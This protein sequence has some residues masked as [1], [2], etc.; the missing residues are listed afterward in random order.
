[1]GSGERHYCWLPK[2]LCWAGAIIFVLWNS[3]P[4]Q[5]YIYSYVD[6]KGTRYIKN[7]PLETPSDQIQNNDPHLQAK[8]I[9]TVARANPASQGISHNTPDK[10]SRTKD[11]K[12]VLHITSVR[13]SRP[14][15]TQQTPPIML[16]KKQGRPNSPEITQVA[17]TGQGDLPTAEVSA[18][19]GAEEFYSLDQLNP[20]GA[21]EGVSRMALFVDQNGKM[22]IYRSK[23]ETRESSDP[24]NVT[25]ADKA[26]TDLKVSPAISD[27][28]TPP[29]VPATIQGRV[30]PQSLLPQE[31]KRP[32]VWPSGTIRVFRD[33]KGFT[34]I[35]NNN[36][37]IN[38]QLAGQKRPQPVIQAVVC[39][40]NLTASRQNLA[41]I[42]PPPEGLNNSF[43]R[44]VSFLDK[45]G[46]LTI[47]NP[48]VNA[49]NKTLQAANAPKFR[50]ENSDLEALM[51]MAA[52]QYRLPLPLVKAV[53][54]AESGFMP[55][56]VSWKG[57]MGLMQLM[58]TTAAWL[59]VKD[60]FC[61]QE[62]IMGG[63]RYLRDLLNRLNGSIPLSLAAYN[64]GLQRVINSGYQIPAIAETQ[65]FVE[66]VIGYFFNYLQQ[67]PAGRKICKSTNL[68]RTAFPLTKG[69]GRKRLAIP[70]RVEEIKG[71]SCLAA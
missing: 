43:S 2:L 42:S 49:L 17:G 18:T 69:I 13:S 15:P 10:I 4:A 22:H 37:G 20:E 28:S 29:I 70:S 5:N 24:E 12:G 55:E 53:I 39:S 68:P 16:A 57:A 9:V 44:I 64:A 48:T 7:I 32:R 54:R 34:H 27:Q 40:D 30:K 47:A 21:C 67:A 65:D 63:C 45:G 50:D 36:A 23:V 35:V 52:Q 26:G 1:M 33:K 41:V 60:P 56:A 31:A 8:N 14:S 58:P 46:R 59:G 51:A 3:T 6:S 25:L 11:K 71:G 62:N 61:P 19:R 38:S 66:K